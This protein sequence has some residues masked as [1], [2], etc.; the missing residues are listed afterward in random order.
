M[1]VTYQTGNSNL[2]RKDFL[3]KTYQNRC[4][5]ILPSDPTFFLLPAEIRVVLAM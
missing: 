4:R 2:R 3:L 5:A 1:A